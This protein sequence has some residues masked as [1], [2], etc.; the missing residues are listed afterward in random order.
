MAPYNF[1]ISDTQFRGSANTNQI[2]FLLLQHASLV[3]HLDL[4]YSSFFNIQSSKFDQY[5]FDPEYS[6]EP[7]LVPSSMP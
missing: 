5:R 7:S 2:P 1:F 6:I 4:G 3:E